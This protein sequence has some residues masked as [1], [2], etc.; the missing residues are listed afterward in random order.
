MLG[1]Q[2]LWLPSDAY[3]SHHSYVDSLTPHTQ[4]SYLTGRSKN[5]PVGLAEVTAI[6][7]ERFKQQE[8]GEICL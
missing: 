4:P 8:G 7:M 5:R 3:V 6:I 2:L 1:L